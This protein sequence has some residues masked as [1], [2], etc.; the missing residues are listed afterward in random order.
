VSGTGGL[1]WQRYQLKTRFPEVPGLKPGSPV[2]VAGVEVGKV[3]AIDFVGDEVEVTFDLSNAM[4]PRVTTASVA[5]LGSLSLL[6]QS[7]VDVSA[8]SEG[9]PVPAWGT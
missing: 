3:T 4:R 1:F 6:G 8:A 9:T 7:T 5:M 2:R